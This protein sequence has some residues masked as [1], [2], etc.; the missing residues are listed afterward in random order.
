M[1]KSYLLGLTLGLGLLTLPGASSAQEATRTIEF[2]GDITFYHDALSP[3]SIESYQLVIDIDETATPTSSSP[4]YFSFG[5]DYV[6]NASVSFYDALGEEVLL[7]VVLEF[8][9][10]EGMY[11][12][13]TLA[14]GP[15]SEYFNF[16]F[17]GS[18]P[19][20]MGD[21]YF[22]IQGS[23]GSIYSVFSESPTF[24]AAPQNV[25]M[26]MHFLAAGETWFHDDPAGNLLG[27]LD[28]VQDLDLDGVAD[29]I[30]SCPS[31]L[32]G[33]TVIFNDWYDSGVP[34]YV[35][36]SGCTVMDHYA[37][38]TAEAAEQPTSIW[39]GF[40]QVYSGPSYCEKQ[41]AYGLVQ[42]GVITYGEARSLRNALYQSY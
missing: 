36:E 2:N 23:P 4:T 11:G 29:D 39:G 28:V 21:I 10:V 38:C 7:P 15:S 27:V 14:T 12:S 34:N 25:T 5:S 42:D 18:T 13:T 16:N 32:M 3:Y 26:Y 41:V 9:G 22:Y 24:V 37:V 31:S 20:G 8:S 35:D 33:E 40:Q 6:L 17:Y 1:K 19:S 30:D